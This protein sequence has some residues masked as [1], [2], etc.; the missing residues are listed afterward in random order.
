MI[1]HRISL[2]RPPQMFGY[3]AL[4]LR[5]DFNDAG[6]HSVYSPSMTYDNSKVLCYLVGLD[7]PEGG[8]GQKSQ[9][10]PVFRSCRIRIHLTGDL[11][12]Y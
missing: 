3:R 5:D 1:K 9:K 2:D 8:K 10:P 7:P 6:F 11:T 12:H 4:S